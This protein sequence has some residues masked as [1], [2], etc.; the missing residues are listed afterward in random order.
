M[1][2][3]Q[4]NMPLIQLNN[5]EFVEVDKDVYGEI[6]N[7]NWRYQ[8]SANGSSGYAVATIKM[9]RLITNARKEEVVDHINHD[10]L[11]NRRENLRIVTHSQNIHNRP[12]S[13]NNKSGY[14]GVHW[15]KKEK[16]WASRISVNGKRIF[17]G[18]FE[19]LE[20][21]AR[22]YDKAA[23]KHVGEFACTNF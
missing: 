4:L 1:E 8:K 12:P 2:T 6:K 7:F 10:K 23:K 20:D 21:A 9:H 14:K 18:Y 3:I 19:N 16:V 5:G 13:V 11:D 15:I 17:L 22:A